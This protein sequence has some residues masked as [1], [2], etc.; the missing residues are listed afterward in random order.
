MASQID[1][2]LKN[3]IRNQD[4]TTR[5]V[6]KLERKENHQIGVILSTSVAWNP[7]SIA[8]GA[9]AYLYVTLSG[10]AADGTWVA[11]AS[12]TTITYNWM[13]TACPDS[14]GITVTI[15]NKTG[16]AVD[17]ASG[18]LRVVAMKVG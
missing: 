7:G 11:M 15:M 1:D 8:D 17:L 16:A 9:T 4:V 2:T 18:T 6:A 10:I 14:G 12:L 3:I 5:R 13:I